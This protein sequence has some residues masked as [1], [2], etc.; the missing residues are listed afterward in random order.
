MHPIGFRGLVAQFSAL[1]PSAIPRGPPLEWGRNAHFW[2]LRRDTHSCA[3]LLC[4]VQGVDRK[5]VSLKEYWNGVGGW[6][7]RV[8]HAELQVSVPS[9]KDEARADANG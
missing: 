2:A 3:S 9:Y 6:V 8:L 5:K 1:S 7:T 4:H